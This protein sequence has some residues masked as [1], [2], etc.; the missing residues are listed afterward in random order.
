MSSTRLPA[1]STTAV[2]MHPVPMDG[3]DGKVA[4]ESARLSGGAQRHVD[5]WARKKV[6]SRL[7]TCE[8]FTTQL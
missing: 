5:V 4:N 7:G 8:D 1:I 2:T 6:R 3:T